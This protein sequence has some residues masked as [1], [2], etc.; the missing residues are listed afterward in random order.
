MKTRKLGISKKKMYQYYI[1]TFP[2]LFITKITSIHPDQTP[3]S[4][5]SN[6]TVMNGEG[7]LGAGKITIPY[8]GRSSL[9][10]R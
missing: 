10:C 5:L 9:N 2:S 8:S 4:T 6:P 7:S 3:A 1:R